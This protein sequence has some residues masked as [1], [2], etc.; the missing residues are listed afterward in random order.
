MPEQPTTDSE[1]DYVHTIEL[2]IISLLL[3]AKGKL[4][5]VR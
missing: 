4:V 5:L 2:Q 1:H 3:E